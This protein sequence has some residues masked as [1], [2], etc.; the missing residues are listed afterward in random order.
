MLIRVAV[1]A[2]HGL[3][4]RPTRVATTPAV[5]L[6]LA[7]VLARETALEPRVAVVEVAPPPSSHEVLVPEV[8]SSFCDRDVRQVDVQVLGHL[9]VPARGA[10]AEVVVVLV[11][12]VRVVPGVDG[13]AGA[14]LAGAAR[15][16][17]RHHGVEQL[18]RISRV[19]RDPS[20]YVVLAQA[21]VVPDHLLE[22]R[23]LGFRARQCALGWYQQLHPF[24][25]GDTNA[26]EQH[27]RES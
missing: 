13:R 9:D 24:V 25:L 27:P 7:L 14:L 6:A 20:K 16:A 8:V 18:L 1:V 21:S 11:R 3:S 12:L 2:F 23:Q 26:V 4:V 10:L 5:A 19:L 17:A 15:A 22:L